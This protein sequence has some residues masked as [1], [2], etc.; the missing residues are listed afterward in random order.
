MSS[1]RWTAPDSGSNGSR[2]CSH[3]T[4]PPSSPVPAGSRVTAAARTSGN[5][6][7]LGGVSLQ[8]VADRFFPGTS[9]LPTAQ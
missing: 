8:A 2:S 7:D 1:R 5:D 6:T 3:T 4:G 9:H